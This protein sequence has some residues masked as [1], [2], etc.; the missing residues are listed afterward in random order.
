MK[1]SCE[2]AW[3]L[4]F[5][6]SADADFCFEEFR[7]GAAGFSGFHGGV[8]F[9][10]VRARDLRDKVQVAF[11][12]GESVRQLIEGNRGSCFQPA[13]GHTGV[14][15]LRGK[16]HRKAACVRSGEKFFRI[17]RKSTR[18]ISSHPSIS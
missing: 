7:D 8:E 12:D 16:R 15:Q 1:T 18:L 10:F 4:R 13:R 11:G 9:A 6:A 17:D 3:T 5:Q 2:N 14:A